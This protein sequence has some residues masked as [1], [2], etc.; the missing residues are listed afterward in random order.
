MTETGHGYAEAE[1]E[2]WLIAQA[3]LVAA[4]LNERGGE[5]RDEQMTGY[6]TR[7]ASA[8]TPPNLPPNFSFRYHVMRSA[9]VN[10]FAL[11][12]GD[13]Y[14][15]VGLLA[16]LDNQAQLA[17]VLAHEQTHVLERHGIEALRSRRRKANAA[18][19]RQHGDARHRQR[20][21]TCRTSRR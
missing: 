8:L 4:D 19:G 20:L 16:Q 18:P 3:N 10:A 12:Q 5:L 21:P 6:V 14:L 7:V 9:D 11:P 15:P 2:G 13:I 1:D 17:Q